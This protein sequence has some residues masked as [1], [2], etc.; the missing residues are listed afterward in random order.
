MWSP[1]CEPHPEQHTSQYI[2]SSNPSLLFFYIS[3]SRSPEYCGPENS[4]PTLISNR[5]SYVQA[6]KAALAA[7]G[8]W[9]P[10][11]DDKLA[12]YVYSALGGFN[13]PKIYFVSLNVMSGLDEFA[14]TTTTDP[15]T[16]T[17]TNGFV[18]RATH[19]H[20]NRGV[21]A[22]PDG[23]GGMEL[24][25]GFN[26]T[27]ED[28]KV[29]LADVGATKIIIEQFIPGDIEGNVL[30]TEYKFHVFQVRVGVCIMGC[31]GNNVV[32]E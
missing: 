9:F 15:A 20:S 14:A 19:L 1:R 8:W 25:R 7:E 27:L 31:T 3:S 28:I 26:M 6:N 24:I 29:D 5:Y 21:Y 17:T 18:I 11:L 23:F 22:L 2:I 12:G 4:F 32:R 16:T 13:P 30:P 10:N